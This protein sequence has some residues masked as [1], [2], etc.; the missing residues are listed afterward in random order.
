M[1]APIVKRRINEG[2]RPRGPFA[3]LRPQH[4]AVRSA[5]GCC[6]RMAPRCVQGNNDW[7]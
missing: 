4:R 1:F 3:N 6:C 5:T 7:R 2:W